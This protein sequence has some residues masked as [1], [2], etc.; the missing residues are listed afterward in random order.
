MINTYGY[1]L[2]W[3]TSIIEILA[4]ATNHTRKVKGRFYI[5]RG[6]WMVFDCLFKVPGKHVVDKF[7]CGSVDGIIVWCM[8]WLE[9]VLGNTIWSSVGTESDQNSSGQLDII[10]TINITTIKQPRVHPMPKY[11]YM[12]CIGTLQLDNT[13]FNLQLLR[14]SLLLDFQ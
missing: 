14:C 3:N 10:S 2:I 7:K 4:Y 11:I 13:S 8:R 5:R 12:H 1:H 9:K 6:P